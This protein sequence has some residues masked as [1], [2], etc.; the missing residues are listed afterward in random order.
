MTRKI[1]VLHKDSTKY[2]LQ[3]VAQGEENAFLDAAFASIKKDMNDPDI[4]P[5]RISVFE[6]EGDFKVLKAQ[7]LNFIKNPPSQQPVNIVS[8]GR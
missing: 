4:H 5:S 6:M 1:L 3:E 7:D 8:H 2:I